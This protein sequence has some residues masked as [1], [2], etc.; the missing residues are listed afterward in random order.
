MSP[1]RHRLRPAPV[2]KHYWMPRCRFDLLTFFAA[3]QTPSFMRQLRESYDCVIIDGP[4]L[5]GVAEARLLPSIAD[6]LLFVVKWGST[7]RD[8]VQNALNL[9]RDSCS[10]EE[11]CNGTQFAIVTQVNLKKHA[12]Y[13][14]GDVGESL[15]RHRKYFACSIEAAHAANDENP[16][17][18]FGDKQRLNPQVQRNETDRCGT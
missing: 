8:I 4:P 14:Y 3:E 5:L 17:T 15:V 12:Q 2:A 9:V 10:L 13:H 11:S 1:T 6:K 16:P 7:R 18:R